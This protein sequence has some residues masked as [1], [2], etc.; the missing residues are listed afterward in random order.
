L[1]WFLEGYLK[2]TE[3]PDGQALKCEMKP[4]LSEV[5]PEYQAEQDSL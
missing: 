2:G 5:P 1:F 4:I 3:F